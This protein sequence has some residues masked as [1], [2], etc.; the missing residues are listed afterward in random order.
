MKIKILAIGKLKEKYLQ[1]ACKE[2]SK[3]LS[4]YAKLEIVEI[5]D[6]KEPENFSQKDIEILKAKE[7]KKIIEK[8]KDKD[9]VILL[10]VQGMFLSSEDMAQKIENLAVT[11]K[12]SLVFIIVGSSGV[13]EEVKNKAD[14]SISFFFFFFPHKLMRVILLEQIYRSFKIIRKEAYHK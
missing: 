1:E 8:I 3:R 12:S 13:S 11:G 10:D 2:Y 7:G 6:E 14:L 4:A 5:P 9:F